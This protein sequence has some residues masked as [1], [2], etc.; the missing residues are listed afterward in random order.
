MPE[1]SAR[2]PVTHVWSCELTEAADD[3]ADSRIEPAGEEV[4]APIEAIMLETRPAGACESWPRA[5][6]YMVRASMVAV[7][8]CGYLYSIGAMKVGSGLRVSD[9]NMRRSQC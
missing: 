7:V 5:E 3:C 6:V 9:T 4:G 8:V 1:E 2:A